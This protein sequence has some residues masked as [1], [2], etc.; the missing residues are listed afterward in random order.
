[1][2]AQ[3][4]DDFQNNLGKKSKV[5]GIKVVQTITVS[6]LR[7]KILDGYAEYTES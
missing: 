6:A 5:Q 2:I 3:I 4:S 1:M 7:M